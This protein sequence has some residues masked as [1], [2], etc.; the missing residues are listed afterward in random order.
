MGI[1]AG[2]YPD[3]T[4]PGFDRYWDG[5]WWTVETRESTRSDESP[6]SPPKPPADDA[7]VESVESEIASKP[8]EK[9]ILTVSEA[10]FVEVVA[11]LSDR[12]ETHA[13]LLKLWRVEAHGLRLEQEILAAH[14]ENLGR[15]LIR[16]KLQEGISWQKHEVIPAAKELGVA[17]RHDF[18]ESVRWLGGPAFLPVPM[19]QAWENF[20][21]P[22]KRIVDAMVEEKNAVLTEVANIEDEYLF[23]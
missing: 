14:A 4:Q 21:A 6:P 7:E 5:N 16:P 12:I 20:N 3:E 10:E 22:V 9:T 1:Q 2:W 11:H 19:D 8:S 15:N 17:M 18:E 13:T 23:V